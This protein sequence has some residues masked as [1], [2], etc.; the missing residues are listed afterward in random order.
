MKYDFETI[1]NRKGQGSAKWDLMYN[2]KK[3]VGDNI[4]PLSVADMEFDNPPQIK[5]GL[6][7]YIDEMILGYTVPTESY[8]NSVIN[9]M[10]KRHN[11]KVE[12]DWIVN[13]PGVV[14]AFFNAV[15][16]FSKE[17][18]GVVIMS[19]VYYPFYSAIE[20]NGRKVMDCPLIEEDNYYKIDFDK[21]DELTKENKLFI[22]C[23]PHNPVGRVWKKEE[24][25]KLEE[26]IIKND[27]IV[28]SDEIHHDLIMPEYEHIVFQTLSDELADRTITCTAASKSFNIA[29]LGMSNIIIKNKKLRDEF[30]KGLDMASIRTSMM[31]IKGTEVAYSECEDW[32]DEFLEI[33][34]KNQR[35]VNKFFTEKYP[36][37]KAPLIEGTY[38]QWI[39]FREYKLSNEELEKLMQEKAEVFLDEG[40]IF[41]E[42]GNGFERINLAAPTIVIEEALNR[43]GKALDE[44]K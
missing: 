7:K 40:Y 41:G 28:V 31:G 44:I 38:L 15:R 36:M 42:L 30:Q 35:L 12:K 39:D 10:D 43:I 21:F 3:D 17:G 33:I 37:I 24:L 14:T 27:V 26:I 4:I 19:P 11:F 9:W 8:Y 20:N 23:S 13:T 25:E 2:T 22:F 5:E 18:D 1:I 32:L 34:D 6:K 16:M 29:G